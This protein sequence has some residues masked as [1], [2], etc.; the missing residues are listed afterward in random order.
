MKK[1]IIYERA[2]FN[3]RSQLLG[4]SADRFITEIHRLA[5]NCEFGRMKD[6][7]IRDHLVVGI[8]DSTLPERLQLEL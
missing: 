3:Q 8:W 7:L 2:R 1:N 4:E 5:E 6:E